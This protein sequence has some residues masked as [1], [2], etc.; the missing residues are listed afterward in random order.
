MHV[1]LQINKLGWRSPRNG[2]RSRASLPGMHPTNRNNEVRAFQ[3]FHQ[4]VEN[5]AFVIARLGFQILLQNTLRIADGLKSQFFVMHGV[6]LRYNEQEYI[7][8]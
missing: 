7:I 4:L 1:V 8:N 6:G 5:G 2:V 3:N